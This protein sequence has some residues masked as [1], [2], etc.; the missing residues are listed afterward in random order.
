MKKQKKQK[1]FGLMALFTII[2]FTALLINTAVT[3]ASVYLLVERDVLTVSANFDPNMERLVLLTAAICVPAGVLIAL[4]FTKVPLKP[5]RDLIDSMD[6]LASGD[7]STRV[8]VGPIMG[9]YPSFVAVANSFN[10]M[11]E[12]LENT[13]MLRSDFIN[14]FSHEFKT[15]I[16]SIAGFAKLLNRGRLTPEQQKEYL[17]AIEEESLRLSYMATNVLNLTKVEN[18]AILTDVEE[19]NLSEQLRACILLLENKWSKK[20]LNFELR[21]EE[22]HRVRGS[23]ELLKQ[24]WINLLDNAIKFSEPGGDIDVDIE[25]GE[26][27]LRVSVRNGGSRIAPEQMDKIFNKFYQA[28]E[29]HASE[30]NGIG[31][32]IAKR[33]VTLH[34]GEVTAQSANDA[35]EFTVELPK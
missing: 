11:A 7:F 31:L 29:S 16:V 22:E 21:L 32:A 27:S 30:G 15:P 14:N 25:E 12:Q 1:H 9:R 5:I 19:Y 26:T 33:I 20:D 3:A 4:L 10:K 2:L 13:E 34:G 28:D 8:K 23:Q 18:Q 6:T 24:V 17:R 35:T